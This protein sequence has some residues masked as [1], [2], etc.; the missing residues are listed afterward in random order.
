LNY[1]DQFVHVCRK[2]G[3]PVFSKKM[4]AATACAMWQEADVSQKSQRT[5]LRYLSADYGCRLVVPKAEV[6]AFGQDH[7]PPVP[8][9]FKDPVTIRTIH[10][11]TKPI[12]KLLEVSVSTHIRERSIAADDSALGIL[13]SIDVVLGSD[14][15][16]GKFKSVIKMIVR[17]DDGS[18]WTVCH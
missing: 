15:G 6:D 1:E 10:I 3:Y 5:I 18:R 14:H 16:Q 7:V 17:G 11:W 8:D 2:M 4:D 9:S 13:K 12:A